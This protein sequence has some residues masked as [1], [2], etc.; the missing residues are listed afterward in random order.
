V[1]PKAAQGLKLRHDNG[2]QYLA[3]D[4]QREVAFLGI[5]SSPS[6]VRAPEG[7]GCAGRIIRTCGRHR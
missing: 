3:D 1:R 5:E 6:F 4:F 7:N 2:T